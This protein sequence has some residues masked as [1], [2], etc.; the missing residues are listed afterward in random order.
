M[1]DKK[2]QVLSFPG[3]KVYGEVK[4]LSNNRVGS[5]VHEAELYWQDVVS[6]KVLSLNKVRVN[7]RVRRS[8]VHKGF[9][10]CVRDQVRS[11]REYK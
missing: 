4:G 1:S 8:R 2:C 11:K 7:E 10:D 9:K 6:Q 5:S 3:R